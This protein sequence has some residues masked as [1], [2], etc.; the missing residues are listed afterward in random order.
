MKKFKLTILSA[1]FLI[2]LQSALFAQNTAI[3]SGNI[4]DDNNNPLELVN[5]SV[6]ETR[7]V[8]TSNREGNFR[9][10]IPANKDLTVVI[11]YL[12]FA[13][14]KIPVNLHPG[15]KQELNKTMNHAASELPNIEITD[16]SR[17]SPSFIQI[18]PKNI[19]QV[20]SISGGVEALLKT[21]GASSNNELSS[22]YSVRGG[23]FD[24]NLVYV[25]DIEIY[26]PFLVRSGQQEGL[27]F[28]NSDL[29]QIFNFQ[30]VVLNRNTAIKCRQCLI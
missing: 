26:R 29:F 17:E 8:T 2:T 18:D 19:T 11:T 6:S 3:I 4:K 10:I 22:Q 1:F 13:T 14:I 30:P 23:N 20:P 12:G 5:I 27:S 9:L 21:L 7:I 28:V 24:E 16:K 15:E 25:N